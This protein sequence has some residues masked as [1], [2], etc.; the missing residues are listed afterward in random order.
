MTKQLEQISALMDG[1][2][3]DTAAIDAMRDNAELASSWHRYHVVR[4]AMRKEM[5]QG[6]FQ[7]IS[8]SIAAAL[9]DEATILSPK[10]S[11]LQRFGGK[12][13]PFARQTG[14]FAVAASVAAAVILG[15]QTFNQP[16]ATQPFVT[17]PTV[18]TQGDLSPVSLNQTRVLP[19]DSRQEVMEARRQI[20]ALIADHEMQLR[21]KSADLDK[22]KTED[23]ASK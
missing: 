7:D 14:Q 16:E 3:R 8:G 15:V 1:E 10:P 6:K 21:F 20:Q 13:V 11:V 9:Q 4:S 18:A 5:P 17:A 23:E 12:V 22:S 19:S 2:S